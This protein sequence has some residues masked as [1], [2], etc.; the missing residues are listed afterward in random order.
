[1]ASGPCPFNFSST[2]RTCFY[3]S[4]VKTASEN[5]GPADFSAT[6]TGVAKSAKA[7]IS[8]GAIDRGHLALV[9]LIRLGVCGRAFGFFL[10]QGRL[11]LTQGDIGKVQIP[12][13]RGNAGRLKYP[14]EGG[15]SRA[16]SYPNLLR[17]IKGLAR[18]VFPGHVDHHFNKINSPAIAC[19][20]SLIRCLSHY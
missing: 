15:I 19:A 13:G 8:P 7:L 6:S 1:M 18:L 5:I 20:F 9:C 17:R 10:A 3:S 4:R 2:D 16:R 11:L 14:G 12:V